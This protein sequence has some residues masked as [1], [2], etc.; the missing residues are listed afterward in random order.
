MKPASLLVCAVSASLFLLPPGAVAATQDEAISGDL[1]NNRL[2]PSFLQLDYIQGGNVPG[3]N[4][5]SGTLGRSSGM[6]DRD[7]LH[8]NVPEGYVL[9]R[10]LVGNRTTV[11][12]AGAFIG[13]AAGS[14]M[15]VAETAIDARGLLGFRIYSLSDRGSDILDDMAVP[16]QGSSGFTTPLGPGDYTLWLQE[17]AV[18][19]YTYRF[20]L[21]LEPATVVPLPPALPLFMAGLGL[22][23]WRLRRPADR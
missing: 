2:A 15:P 9:A 13:L 6:P 18:G 19:S 10:L 5:I 22:L 4:V 12:G 1:S 21:L 23:G 16:A 8:V 11:G 17:L 14:T 20:N 3:S 7:Y